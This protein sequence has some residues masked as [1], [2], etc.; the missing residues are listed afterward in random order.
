MHRVS[1]A[2]SPLPDLLEDGALLRH[3]AYVGGQWCGAPDGAALLVVNP[4]DGRVVGSVPDVGAAGAARAVASAAAA[5]PA[6]RAESPRSRGEVLTRWA[7]SMLDHREDLATIVTVEQ[8][9]PL[10]ESRA[11][12]D[13]AAGFLQWFAGEAQRL[14]GE[15]I[16]SHLPGRRLVVVREPV[17]VAAAITPWNFPSAMIT[18]KAGAA[19]AA[20][21]SI[22]VMPACETPLS[23]LA[24]AELA[25]R[26]GVPS[27]VF[28]V[29]TGTPEPIGRVFTESDE[30]RQ[31]SFT[32]STEIGRL[33]LARSAATVKRVSMELGGSAPFVVFDDA[34]LD[35]VV[36]AAVTAK[37]QT[38]GQDCLAANRLFV[39]DRVYDTFA[40]RFAAAVGR[41]VVGNGLSPGVAQGPLIDDESIVRCEAHVADALAGGA[42]LLVGGRRHALGGRFFE[43]TALVEVTPAMRVCREE[44]F[45]PIAP[46]LR[47][48]TDEEVIRLANQTIYGLAAYVYGA[49]LARLWRVA[50]RLEYGMVGL[51]AA[52]ITGA[53][54][55]FGG[56]KHSG[57]GREGSR[58]GLDE[59]TDLKYLCLGVGV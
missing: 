53:P 50:E 42:R 2:T 58:H 44:T 7:A 55:P 59:Y 3:E 57:L 35:L 51:N 9:K 39:H 19:L 23:A 24:L 31:L 47:F 54:V 5:Y 32:G 10:A 11:E 14:Y 1:R 18:R 22:V 36:P 34:D 29:V 15:V 28:S 30:V 48:S 56:V 43:P 46:L 52:S 40:E 38:T 17:G 37:F 49:D 21:C 16:P 33:L 20:G 27:G 25:E 26:A 41:L 45:G 12:I 6:W 4:A 8:G 13:Y